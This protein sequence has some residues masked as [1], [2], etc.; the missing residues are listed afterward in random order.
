[1][2]ASDD[3]SSMSRQE[4][5]VAYVGS[6]R[7]SDHS[8]DVQILAPALLAFGRLLREANNEFNGNK[9]TAKVVVV[10]DFEHKCFNINFE[11]I[12]G[13][14]EQLKTLLGTDGAKSA[15][16]V[17]DWVGII[18]G[19]IGG[20]LSFLKYLQWR[21]GRKIKVTR[22]V[23]SDKT[24]VVEVRIEG[25]GNAVHIHNHIHALSENAKALRATRDAFLPLGHDGFDKVQL[26]DKD[27]VIEEIGSEDVDG[28]IAS[29]NVGIEE[30]K[31]TEP[32]V[33]ETPAWLSVYSPVYDPLAPSWRFRL[34]TEVIYADISDTL[35]AKEALERGGTAVEDAYQ[36]RL[37]ITTEVGA[38]GKKKQ[39][40]YKVIEVVRFVG[41]P[42]TLRQSTFLDKP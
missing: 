31:E 6:N 32:E 10:S 28:I 21:R 9:S 41:A 27:T 17:L 36:V 30:A 2:A 23:D 11:L 8:I 34:G 40:I 15:K 38:H 13:F 5:A 1:M 19:P 37:Q 7:E 18:G 12:V 22:L 26:K 24:G 42:P 16:D 3:G 29:C 4:F 25:D 20:T 35:I 14:Y 33:G 39:P